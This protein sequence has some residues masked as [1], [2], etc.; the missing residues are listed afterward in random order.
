VPDTFS[1]MG[2]EAGGVTGAIPLSG[3]SFR[4]STQ[5]LLETQKAE[6]EQGIAR[7]DKAVGLL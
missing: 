6:P 1:P 4:R 7:I 3:R 5:S 2:W